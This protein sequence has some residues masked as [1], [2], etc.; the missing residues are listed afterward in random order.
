MVSR[1]ARAAVDDLKDAQSQKYSSIAALH[2][3]SVTTT[4]TTVE[5][6]IATQMY[7]TKAQNS[8]RRT[9]IIGCL[10]AE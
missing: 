1:A 6:K 10:L 4:G 5:E 2:P 8:R 9:R 3:S 7:C